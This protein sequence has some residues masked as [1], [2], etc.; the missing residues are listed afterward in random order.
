MIMLIHFYL[1]SYF[2]KS[3]EKRLDKDWIFQVYK[4]LFQ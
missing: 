2:L 1:A 3:I 4:N